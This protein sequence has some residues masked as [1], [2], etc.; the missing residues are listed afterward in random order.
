[1]K[2]VQIQLG[3]LLEVLEALSESGVEE[4]VI[5]SHQGL[6]AFRDANDP[7]NIITFATEDGEEFQEDEG[8]LH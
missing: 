3:E 6:P 8:G 4:V 1:M 5:F 7:D 2:Q